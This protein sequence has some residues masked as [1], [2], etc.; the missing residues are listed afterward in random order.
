MKMKQKLSPQQFLL[1]QMI[2]LPVTSLEQRLKEELE[3]NPVLEISSES[4]NTME[5]LPER[6]DDGYNDYESL[7][8][9]VPTMTTTAT[10]SDR[11]ATRILTSA[12]PSMLPNPRFSTICS[13]S[14]P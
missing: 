12:K 14:S 1:M 5:S 2:Q 13:S 4:D 11:S 8:S 9:V 6:D 3:K 10:A 7:V